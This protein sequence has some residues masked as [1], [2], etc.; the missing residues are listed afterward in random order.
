MVLLPGCACCDAL[1]CPIPQ[2]LP[3]AVDQPGTF[4]MRATVA[5]NGAF[6]NAG[7][8]FGGFLSAYTF[9]WRYTGSPIVDSPLDYYAPAN[10][11]AER[12]RCAQG[13]SLD[14][15]GGVMSYR[16][17]I[18]IRVPDLLD[19][20]I[21]RACRASY[22]VASGS[23][24]PAINTTVISVSLYPGSEVVSV[25]SGASTLTVTPSTPLLSRRVTVQGSSVP[26]RVSGRSVIS[27]AT[28]EFD[29]TITSI[30]PHGF[31]NPLP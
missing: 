10:Y 13:E 31:G 16:S 18:D 20:Q 11:P 4:E 6:T 27:G 1:S 21:D 2:F 15:F 25:T 14:T 19:L 8:V 30:P 26:L 24:V 3:S 23:V 7:N 22:A 5:K 17:D 29:F 28:I 9:A 12:W